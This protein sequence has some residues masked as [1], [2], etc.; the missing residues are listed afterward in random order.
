MFGAATAAMITEH[1]TRW[2]RQRFGKCLK[3]FKKDVQL[4]ASLQHS[5]GELLINFNK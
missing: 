5:Y 4:T 2:L 3:R 1:P